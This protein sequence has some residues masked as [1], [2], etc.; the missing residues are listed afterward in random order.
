V[1]IDEQGVTRDAAW[2][3]QVFDAYGNQVHRFLRR[4][5]L[6]GGSVVD[7]DDLTAEVFAVTW[8]RRQDI[9]HDAILAW[10]YGVARNV[11]AAHARRQPRAAV[12]F[13]QDADEFIDEVSD[14]AE[15]VTD[16]LQLREAWQQLSARER[17]I[18]ALVAWEGLT[19]ES[20][21][22]VLGIKIGSASS[23]ISRAR[24][25]FRELLN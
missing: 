7:A 15:L 21:A 1:T 9:P 25:R 11:L 2:F 24:Q 12:T 4:R 13:A 5:M 22:E 8:R 16:S 17:Q 6:S 23:A 3:A 20:V 18:L 19:E 10:L 14:P